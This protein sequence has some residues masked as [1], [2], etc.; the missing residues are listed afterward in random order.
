M[1][2]FISD[3]NVYDE[4]QLKI[5]WLLSILEQINFKVKLIFKLS[6]FS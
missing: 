4:M 3:K 2:C 1:E 6:S 5:Y